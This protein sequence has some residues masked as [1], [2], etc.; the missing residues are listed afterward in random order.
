TL[1][2]AIHSLQPLAGGG[3]LLVGARAVAFEGGDALVLVERL[4][5]LLHRGAQGLTRLCGWFALG[6]GDSETLLQPAERQIACH[7]RRLDLLFPIGDHEPLALPLEPESI[8]S[9]SGLQLVPRPRCPQVWQ[10]RADAVA[11][12]GIPGA[13]GL[14]P[15]AACERRAWRRRLPVHLVDPTLPRPDP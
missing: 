8:S 2:R 9:E 13:L 10:V 15:F 7:A 4:R 14:P 5:H 12:R 11:E 6:V 3:E 1:D